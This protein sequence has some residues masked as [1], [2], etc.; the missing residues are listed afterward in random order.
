MIARLA[1]R[2]VF[3]SGAIPG[4]RV[5]ARVERATKNALFASTIQVEQPSA[6]RR[7]SFADPACGG[8]L[9]S[10]IEYTRQLTLKRQVIEDA[11]ARIGGVPS[12]PEFA[13][14]P[15][16]EAGYRM[17]ARLHVRGR[18]IGFFREGTHDLCDVR[19]T[20][21]L[22]PATCDTLDRVAAA[23]ASLGGVVREV[24]LSENLDASER[25]VHVETSEP[26]DPRVLA[27]LT[28][29]EG[30]TPPPFV[31]D[32]VRLDGRAVSLRR[33]VRA[34]F[35][36]NRYLLHALAAHVCALVPAGSSVLD[37]YAGAGLFSVATAVTRDAAVTAVEGDR[38]AAEDLHAN[39]SA[40]G[41]RVADVHADVES[42]VGRIRA[43]TTRETQPVEVVIVDP[44]RTGVSAE[45]LAGIVALRPAR[46]LYVSCDPATLARDTRRIREAGYSLD[47]I[48]AFDLF[49][50]TPHVETVVLFV[51]G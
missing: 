32:V 45:A 23:A 12:L 9:Y 44:P 25:T 41:A 16:E 2:V 22:L 40:A 35:Q 8:C 21:Q 15:S 30:L 5:R 20:H 36:G 26:V 31:T 27:S 11:F 47:R 34:F 49:P 37:L 38:L 24:E 18:R 42:F 3:V 13:V 10:H 33:H 1:G 51:R 43:S 17:R 39:R 4:E 46:L 50:N 14:A 19:A 6:D 48:D 7:T 29:V 28:G